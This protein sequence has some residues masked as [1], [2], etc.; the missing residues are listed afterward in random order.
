LAAVITALLESHF[1]AA[2]NIALG[3][4]SLALQL[5]AAPALI[6]YTNSIFFLIDEQFLIRPYA[7]RILLKDSLVKI[8]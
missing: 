2:A 3:F 5:H 8:V 7:L 6:F 1:A 4:S